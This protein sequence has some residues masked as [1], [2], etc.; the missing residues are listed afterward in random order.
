MPERW[1]KNQLVHK[2]AIPGSDESIATLE[3]RTGNEAGMFTIFHGCNDEEGLSLSLAE[4]KRL[5]SRADE[6][7]K[8]TF[9]TGGE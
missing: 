2:E 5:V 8:S 7:H 1:K 6:Y 4:L 9:A 3:L